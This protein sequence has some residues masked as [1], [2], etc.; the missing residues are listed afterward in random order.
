MELEIINISDEVKWYDW[1][2]EFDKKYD[3]IKDLVSIE[4]KRKFIDECINKID[5][6]WDSI[7]KT[8]TIKVYFKLNIVKD[9]REKIGRYKFKVSE[10]LNVSEI[11]NIKSNKLCRKIKNEKP[12]NTVLSN[13]STV[14]D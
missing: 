14:I 4:D 7:T 11:S 13:H 9:I 10:G 5:V 8:H 2:I 1:L 3:D 6:C 12:P